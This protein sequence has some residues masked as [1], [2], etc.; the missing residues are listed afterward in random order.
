MS[1]SAQP[2]I[3]AGSLPQPIGAIITRNRHRDIAREADRLR[4]ELDVEFAKRLREARE[5]GEIGN[6]DDYLQIKEEE[7]VVASRL[8]RLRSLLRT[9]IVRDES[10]APTG[11]ISVGSTVELTDLETGSRRSHKL[12]GG[13]EALR[14]GEVSINSP[15]GRALLGKNQDDEV[16][17]TLPNGAVVHVKVTK[18]AAS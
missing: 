9:A 7:A 17:I 8:H 3:P 18:V 6:N 1:T 13:Y 2:S 15:V 4:H 16:T 11:P 12:T 14:A 10:T 5:F